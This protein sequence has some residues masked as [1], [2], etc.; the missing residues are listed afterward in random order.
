M[1]KGIVFISPPSI[2][3]FTNFLYLGVLYPPISFANICLVFGDPAASTKDCA[4]AVGVSFVIAVLP[5]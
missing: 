3:S 2:A 4:T 1:A 5:F